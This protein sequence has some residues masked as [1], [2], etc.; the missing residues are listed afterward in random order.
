MSVYTRSKV[1]CQLTGKEQ[2]LAGATL[3]AVLD[4][5]ERKL[6]DRRRNLGGIQTKGLQGR[7]RSGSET[8]RRN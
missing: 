7:S 3:S 5:Y 1:S 2:M 8:D 4:L 6:R